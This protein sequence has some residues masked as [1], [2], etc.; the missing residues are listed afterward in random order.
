MQVI[1][2]INEISFTAVLRKVKLLAGFLP[3]D[4]WVH[5]DVVDGVFAPNLT[6]G[7]IEEFKELKK[8][9]PRLN[10]EIH[11]MVQNADSLALDWLSSG[12]DQIIVHPETLADPEL[13]RRQAAELKKEVALSS[14]PDSDA[15]LFIKQ[16]ENFKLVQVLA[17]LPG[18][19]GQKFQHDARAKIQLIR[20]K[21]PRAI[22]EVDGGMNPET[23]A[24]VKSDG[25]DI[26]VAASYIFGSE[27]PDQAYKVLA[28]I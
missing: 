14:M 2:A 11:L 7:N 17:V 8:E 6:W 23:A 5:I 26:V 18:L 22:I 21:L 9:F 13:I 3:E 1:P 24:L 15:E 19:A 27:H 28:D 20:K 10:F 25:A 12:A 4:G 16:A